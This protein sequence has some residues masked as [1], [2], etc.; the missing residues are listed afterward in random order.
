MFSESNIRPETG[1]CSILRDA[2]KFPTTKIQAKE[3]ISN[4]ADAKM[5]A[6]FMDFPNISSNLARKTRI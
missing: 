2:L 5:W 3:K 1:N 6:P 4:A